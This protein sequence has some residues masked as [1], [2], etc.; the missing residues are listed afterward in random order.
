MRVA[1]NESIYFLLYRFERCHFASSQDSAWKM[2]SGGDFPLTN[3]IEFDGRTS[4]CSCIIVM[5]LV[6]AT[7]YSCDAMPCLSMVRLRS[8]VTR[9]I[10]G[11]N[12]AFMSFVFCAWSVRPFDGGRMDWYRFTRMKTCVAKTKPT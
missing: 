9:I 12:F 3:R 8:F 1:A 4:P 2:L 10:Y 6:R 7:V 5:L 11:I